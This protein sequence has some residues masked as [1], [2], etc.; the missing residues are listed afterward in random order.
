MKSKFDFDK[1][2]PQ[3]EK[4][5]DHMTEF[6]NSQIK[7]SYGLKEVVVPEPRFYKD[8]I[9]GKYPQSYTYMSEEFYKPDKKENANKTALVLI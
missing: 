7:D 4:L 8:S 6:I 9:K 3:Y 1:H 2:K 5:V